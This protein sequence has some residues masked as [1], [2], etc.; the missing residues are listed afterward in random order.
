MKRVTIKE[1]WTLIERLRALAPKRPL[2]YS[3]S[4]KVAR[5]QASRLRMW[6]GAH[7][8]AI[9]LAWL[10]NQRAVPVQLVASYKLGEESGLTTDQIGGKLQMFINESEPHVRQRFSLLHEFKHVLD[11]DDA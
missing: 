9:N 8:P 3:E 4:V 10:L 5:W 6:D 1:T 2:T 11:F 7:D